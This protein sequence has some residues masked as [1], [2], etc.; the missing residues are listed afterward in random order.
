MFSNAWYLTLT[1][2]QIDDLA[3]Q[4]GFKNDLNLPNATQGGP[5]IFERFSS[6]R[7]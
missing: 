6:L 1:V 2:H 7:A 4:L 3:R 5:N